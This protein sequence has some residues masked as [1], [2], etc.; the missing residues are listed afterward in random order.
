VVGVTNDLT[1]R[2]NAVD[3]VR[4]CYSAAVTTQ[5]AWNTGTSNRHLLSRVGV[6]EDVS[7]TPRGFLT[8]LALA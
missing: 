2:F 7:C 6:H 3:L 4:R 1:A 5:R 8:R